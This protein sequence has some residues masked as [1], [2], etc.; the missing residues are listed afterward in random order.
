MELRRRASFLAP[1]SRQ[2]M[3]EYLGLV[4]AAI[5]RGTYYPSMDVADFATDVILWD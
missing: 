3:V 5:R 4:H 1:F 2:H